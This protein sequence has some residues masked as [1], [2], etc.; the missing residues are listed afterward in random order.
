MN[1]IESVAR[2]SPIDTRIV[3]AEFM[4]LS[5]K[6]Q[7][8]L[9]LFTQPDGAVRVII[10]DGENAV[11]DITSS[12]PP[13]KE[14]QYRLGIAYW[15]ENV[16]HFQAIAGPMTLEQMALMLKYSAEFQP[17]N[18]V[19]LRV[20]PIGPIDVSNVNSVQFEFEEVGSDS[21]LPDNGGN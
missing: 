6:S 8:R 17:E 7:G 16:Q 3:N 13:K 11:L 18:S 5:G 15:K 12:I 20:T 10:M 19:G 2:I 9:H 4:T 21:E 14:K 1:Y